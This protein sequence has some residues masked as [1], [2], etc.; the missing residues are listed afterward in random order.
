MGQQAVVNARLDAAGVHQQELVAGPLA[1]AE[2]AVTGDAGGVL[3]NGE[4][5]TGQLIKMVDLPT[6]G[7]PTMATIGFAMS[8]FLPLYSLIV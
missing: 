8:A 5:L 7:R 6:L 3:D 2:D 1:V 4:A